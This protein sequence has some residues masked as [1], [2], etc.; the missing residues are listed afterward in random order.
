MTA[1]QLPSCPLFV[2]TAISKPLTK[3]FFLLSFTTH[4]CVFKA[5]E[6]WRDVISLALYS[7][8]YVVAVKWYSTKHMALFL[9]AC[10]CN[11]VVVVNLR[12]IQDYKMVLSTIVWLQFLSIYV[13]T[14]S[15][16]ISKMITTLRNACLMSI[17]IVAAT[18]YL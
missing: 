18:I 3:S 4:I 2:L 1:G 12:R 10:L 7:E 5:V 13:N 11:D 17:L 9:C 14:I 16:N 8:S 6:K 15:V